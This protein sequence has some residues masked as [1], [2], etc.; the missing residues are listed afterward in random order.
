MQCTDDLQGGRGGPS[1]RGRG[2]GPGSGPSG[3]GGGGG[4]QE[5]KK[6]ESIL[7]LANYVDKSVKVKF[8]GGRE[9]MSSFLLFAELVNLSGSCRGAGRQNEC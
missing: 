3:P 5:R 7:N 2:G 6:K 1:N 9:G 4:Q 8:M